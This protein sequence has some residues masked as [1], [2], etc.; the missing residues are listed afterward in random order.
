MIVFFLK[1]TKY[2]IIGSCHCGTIASITIR[3]KDP[4]AD[5]TIIEMNDTVSFLSCGIA[6]AIEKV[7]SSLDAMF[8]NSIENLNKMGVKVLYK[9][10]VMSIDY[11]A[12]SLSY[13][14]NTTQEMG[15]I[16]YDKLLISSGSR[17]INPFKNLQVDNQ[18]IFYCKNYNDAKKLIELKSNGD[19]SIAI[20]G[21]GY[22]GVELAEAFAVQKF[23]VSIIEKAPRIL[24]RYFSKETTDV[25]EGELK[26]HGVEV[27]VGTDVNGVVVK[28]QKVEIALSSGTR[29]VD[30]CIVCVGFRPNTAFAVESSNGALKTIGNG[31]ILVDERQRTSIKNVFAA[32]DAATHKSMLTGEMTY[33]PLA[34]V[35]VK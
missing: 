15:T 17:P 30:Y 6:L 25:L 4:K 19:K 7:S 34:T 29:E 23:K 10:E 2:V 3:Q 9:H 28:G 8:Y 14:N 32:G 31:A 24:E 5:I 27:I 20:I 13:R 33:V 12:Q 22:I 26:K 1:M 21:S 16:S 18:H 35:A 11:P